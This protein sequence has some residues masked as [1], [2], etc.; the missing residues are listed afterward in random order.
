VTGGGGGIFHNIWS[1]NTYARSGFH[2]SDTS[3]P[4]VVYELSA[5]H[6][7]FSEIRLDRVQHWT[8]Y[9]PQTEEEVSTSAEAVAFEITDST[10]ITIANY[11]AYRV[12]RAYA[13]YPTAMRVEGASQVR[14]RNVAVNAEHG[15]AACDAAG[16][17]TILRGGK[18][19]YDNA[20]EDRARGRVVRERL[21]AVLDLDTRRPAPA[22]ATGT[23]AAGAFRGAR[24]AKLAGGF[25]SIAGPAVDGTGVLYFVDHREQRI[26]S[27]SSAA[28]LKVVRDAPLDPVNLGVDRS[29]TLLVLSSAGPA[30]TVY[31]LRPGDPTSA[32]SVQQPVPRGAPAAGTTAFLLPA[33]IW[34][35]GQFRNHLDLATYEYETHAQMFARE[36][37]TPAPKA[38]LSAD[39]TLALPAGRVFTQGP[40]GSYPGMDETGWRWSHALDA[41]GLIAARQGER[42]YVTS[43]AENR[44][45]R[46]VVRD[47]GTLGDLTVFTERGGEGAIADRDGNVYVANGQIFVYGPTGT[48]LGRIDVPERPTGLRFGG[49]GGRTLYVLTHHA[50]YG[51]TLPVAARSGAAAK[52]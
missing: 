16:C 50:L 42:V 20:V 2:V 41:F 49:P 4:G 32:L 45:Y 48:P 46:G 8:F 23:A 25:H 38:Y 7:L 11:K 22:A 37:T 13:P 40:D 18:F 47:D 9:G 15:Y 31:A 36:V 10:D 14:V 34:A 28:G 26:F 39:G 43:G 27:W 12:T 52:P 30:G 5:E 19:A 21:F 33:T 29:G 44:T 51:V 24:V 6:H 1:P 35:D 17:G 3:T